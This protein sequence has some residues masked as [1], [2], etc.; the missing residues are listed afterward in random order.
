MKTDRFSRACCWPTKSASLLGRIEASSESSSLRSGVTRRSVGRLAPSIAPSP[1]VLHGSA[2]S[3]GAASPRSLR[4]ARNRFGR[5]CTLRIAQLD[6]RRDRVG[7]RSARRERHARARHRHGRAASSPAPCLSVR[8]RCAEPA[9]GRRP[10]RG[11]SAA[12]SAERQ[13]ALQFARAERGQHVQ[14]H[15]AADILHRLQQAEPFAFFGGD[16]AVELDGVVG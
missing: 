6:Q 16:E 8:W 9:S 14:R 5:L 12:L 11:R 10:G 1:A 2:T 7:F 3:T 13:C 4:G 15:A